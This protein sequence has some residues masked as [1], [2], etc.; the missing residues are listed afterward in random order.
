VHPRNLHK[1]RY[2]FKSLCE[3]LPELSAFVQSNP[4]GDDTID[5]ADPAGVL[6][7]N[8]ALL[9]NDYSVEHWMI[10]QGYL[11]PPI[12]GRA[13]YIH[14]LADLI[15]ESNPG[16]RVLDI[17]MGANCIYPILG[18]QIYG[19][20]FVGSDIDTVALKSARA[21]VESNACLRNK[22][23]LI[24]Q[25]DAN[26][27]FTGLIRPADRF[28]AVMCNPPF[29]TSEEAAQSSADR[30]TKNLGKGAGRSQPL[31]NFGGQSNELWCAGGEFE[32]IER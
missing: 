26:S 30:K 11:C 25:K 1:S 28:A 2:D 7:L 4:T 10:P 24:Q 14:H 21:I 22:V 5:F 18:S 15:G 16:S 8:R 13:D 6:C 23:R 19:W 20:K 12:P 9:A 32:F 17:G 27:I 29:H 3:A 31:Q